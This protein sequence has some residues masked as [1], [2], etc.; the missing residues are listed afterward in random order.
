MVIKTKQDWECDSKLISTQVL[1]ET[2][3]LRYDTLISLI[4]PQVTSSQPPTFPSSRSYPIHHYHT[5]LEEVLPWIF[6]KS[7]SGVHP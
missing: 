2:Y 6:Q 5:M 4:I 7:S 3:P 1:K